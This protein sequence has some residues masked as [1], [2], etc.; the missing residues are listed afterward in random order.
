[1]HQKL[2]GYNTTTQTL[3]PES[4]G[5]PDYLNYTAQKSDNGTQ[6][7]YYDEIKIALNAQGYTL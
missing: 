5:A 7:Y 1:M 4:S 2:L 6:Q 3:Y